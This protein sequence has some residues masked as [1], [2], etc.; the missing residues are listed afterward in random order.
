MRLIGR[1][2]LSGSVHSIMIFFWFFDFFFAD[3]ET[4]IWYLE[5]DERLQKPPL[6]PRELYGLMTA[7]WN[8]EPMDR[9]NFQELKTRLDA[10]NPKLRQAKTN[11]IAIP[12]TTIDIGPLNFQEFLLHLSTPCLPELE[13]RPFLVKK[14]ET[15]L[16]RFIYILVVFHQFLSIFSWL[17]RLLSSTYY[18]RSP[19]LGSMLL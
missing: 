18:K 7:C 2:S 17:L 6:C 4:L 14:W 3:T 9:P 1:T 5:K 10:F 12:K 11:P 16:V 19:S 8:M 13:S 15:V